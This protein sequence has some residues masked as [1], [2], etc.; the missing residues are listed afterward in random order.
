[1]PPRKREEIDAV[2]APYVI[3]EP[4]APEDLIL[5]KEPPG[6]TPAPKPFLRIGQL[7]HLSMNGR[8]LQYRE[9]LDWD[10]RF[11]KIRSDL[12][13]SPQTEIVLLP[14]AQIEAIGL[15]DER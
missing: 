8:T 4:E 3:Q 1:M 13:V 11:L 2:P 10:E 7:V 14:W 9:I 12:S 15:T 5:G 6:C